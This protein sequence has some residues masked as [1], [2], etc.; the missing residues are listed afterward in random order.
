MECEGKTPLLDAPY[1]V[2]ECRPSGGSA[3]TAQGRER[4]GAEGQVSE[5]GW[6]PMGAEE[7][8]R[9]QVGAQRGADQRG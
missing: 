6:A 9:G 2:F 3:G 1:S 8:G 7:R 4:M 5:R